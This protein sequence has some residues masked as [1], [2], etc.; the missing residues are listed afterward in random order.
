MGDILYTVTSHGVLR[1]ERHDGNTAEEAELIDWDGNV[2]FRIHEPESMCCTG[3]NP[4]AEDDGL[5]LFG[6]AAGDPAEAPAQIMKVDLQGNT[7]WE[8]ELPF[9][10]DKHDFAGVGPAVRT[11]DGGYLAIVQNLVYQPKVDTWR[12]FDSLV[13]LDSNGLICWI[14]E[15]T[16]G[17]Q[18]LAHYN[19]MHVVY[20]MGFVPGENR[21][22][23]NYL[24]LDV[25]G[26]DLGTTQFPIPEAGLSPYNSENAFATGEKLIPT[27]DGLWQLVSFWE[28]DPLDDDELPAMVAG[29]SL[30]IRVPEP[31]TDG[32]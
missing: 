12:S 6:Q 32:Q 3:Y 2:L 21:Y 27:G 24:W 4:I 9:V 20:G 22:V 8:T 14:H 18:E 13:K 7:V 15:P 16:N 28:P 10:Q 25:N 5:I 29:D 17:F 30:L 1:A 26:R 23:M 11:G 19:G 31:G